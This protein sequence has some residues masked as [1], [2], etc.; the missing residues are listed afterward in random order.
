MLI[1]YRFLAIYD[2][3]KQV[4]SPDRIAAFAM[5]HDIAEA[6]VG[7]IPT[8]LK[9]PAFEKFEDRVRESIFEYLGVDVS[10][11]NRCYGLVHMA[12]LIASLYECSYAT[13]KGYDLSLIYSAR[14]NKI[15]DEFAI[16]KIDFDRLECDT[17]FIHSNRSYYCYYECE[18]GSLCFRVS[19]GLLIEF[20][21]E[22]VGCTFS[23]KRNINNPV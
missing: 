1:A 4:V 17:K 22:I 23:A 15:L 11:Y 10:E 9:H 8:P 5:L 13:K 20:I 2:E 3:F 14:L 18:D 6:L 19:R 7:D 12:D 21:E 16:D